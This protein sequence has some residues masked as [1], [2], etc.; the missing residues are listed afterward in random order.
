M[1]RIQIKHMICDTLDLGVFKMGF[2]DV[3][4]VTNYYCVATK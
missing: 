3:L 1:M 4:V 2:Q